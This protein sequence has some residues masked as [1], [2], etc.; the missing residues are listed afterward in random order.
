MA[1]L[2]FRGREIR[3]EDILYIRALIEGHPADSRRKLSTRLCEAWNW[4]QSK[5]CGRE[6]TEQNG[7][8][9][10]AGCV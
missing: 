5:S 1:T 10:F 6:L 3:P 7:A 2:R 8:N 4:R 9:R